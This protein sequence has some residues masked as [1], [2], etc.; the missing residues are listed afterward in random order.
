[1]DLLWNYRSYCDYCNTTFDN[2]QRRKRMK[3]LITAIPNI[4]NVQIIDK[5]DTQCGK[6]DDIEINGKTGK[7]NAFLVG[8]NAWH[9]KGKDKGILRHFILTKVSPQKEV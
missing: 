1:M 8:A 6:V 9:G 4:L 3:K 2:Y 5:N 7:V